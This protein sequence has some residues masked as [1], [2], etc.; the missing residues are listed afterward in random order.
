MSAFA[1]NNMAVKG[2]QKGLGVAAWLQQ[3]P[4][5]MT[6]PP[7]RLMQIGSLFWQS[8]VLYVAAR[9]D[10]A[11]LLG[12]E[13]LNIDE[14]A[15]KAGC[16]TDNLHRLLRMLVSMG[17]F[18]E[19]E[20]GRIANNKTSAYLDEANPQC[21]RAMILMHNSPE[22]T[23]PW[24]EELE[25]GI[26]SG[27]IPFKLAHGEKLFDYMDRHAEFESL[28]ARAMDSTEALVGNSFLTDFDW[29][30]YER[31]I[32][33]GGS[34]GSKAIALLEA[35]PKL[36]AVVF[37]RPQVIDEA[38]GYW[39]GKIDEAVLTRL[40]FVAGDARESVPAAGD[41]DVY[42]ACALFHGLSDA[43]SI[44]ILRNIRAASQADVAIFEAVVP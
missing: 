23:R 5:R 40:E 2:F 39:Q 11:T 41:K 30:R 32:D 38:R 18:A 28:F 43:D 15:A 29:G 42:L 19:P 25:N 36:R 31:L 10:L 34:K 17:I 3:L 16:H 4:N 13:P 35:F 12:N 8:R 33:V 26:R 24:T 6:P 14:L 44:R 20:P 22:M 27:D 21:V 7:M 1:R 37:D 9:L